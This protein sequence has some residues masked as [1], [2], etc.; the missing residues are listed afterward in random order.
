MPRQIRLDSVSLDLAESFWR[1]PASARRRAIL[2]ACELSVTRVG[3]DGEDVAAALEALRRSSPA[4]ASLR[5]RLETRSAAL[6]DAYLE[7][8]ETDDETQMA[9]AMRLFSKARTFS[10]LAFAMSDGDSQLH[11]ALYEAIASV[12]DSA[13]IAQ[14]AERALA[15]GPHD[16][17]N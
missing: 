7:L 14:V 15:N 6:D 4:G 5:Q 1:A 12:D 10:A 13:E 2:A 9:G 8:K 16:K 3:L 17:E 11:E